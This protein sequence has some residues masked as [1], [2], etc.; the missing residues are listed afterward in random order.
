MRGVVID[1]RFE[2]ATAD[3]GLIHADEWWVR[4]DPDNEP[5]SGD[6]GD[7]YARSEMAPQD[8]SGADP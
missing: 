6:H 7:W 1:E 3:A 5:D 8:H 2:D 4:Y